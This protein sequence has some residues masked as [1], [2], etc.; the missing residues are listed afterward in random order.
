[1]WNL[2]GV[3]ILE[4]QKLQKGGPS[5]NIPK[6]D[7]PYSQHCTISE[8]TPLNNLFMETRSYH[9]YSLNDI[10]FEGR[11][12]AYGAYALRQAYPAHLKKAVFYMFAG[13]ALLSGVAYVG[14]PFQ[15]DQ[16]HPMVPA[17]KVIEIQ[18][19]V[20]P[21]EE[22]PVIQHPVVKQTPAGSFSPTKRFV[23]TKIVPDNS[24]I[25]EEIPNHADFGSQEPGLINNMGDPAAAQVLSADLPDGSGLATTGEADANSIRDFVEQMPEF[26]GGTAKMYRF[27]RENL[28]YP[29]AAQQQGLEGTVVVTFVVS[30]TGEITDIQVVK[31]LG[32]GTAEEAM[33][34]VR[35][36]KSWKPGIQNGRAVPV[37]FTLPLRFSLAS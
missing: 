31:D 11:N 27:I 18:S 10:I 4:I 25:I 13:L 5:Q 20:L 12:Q 15:S 32:G 6:P 26:P 36:M 22:E 17:S 24:Q 8:P 37:R 2:I 33:R 7:I 34:V 16:L 28:R 29:S 21:K 14:L 30:I 35:K 9:N 19:I 3:Y 1:L 23:S